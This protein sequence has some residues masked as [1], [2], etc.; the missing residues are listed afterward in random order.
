MYNKRGQL[1]ISVIVAIVIVGVILVL[2]LV[3]GVNPFVSADVN[4]SAFLIDC[5]E[6][7][8][9]DNLEI[10]GKQ[11]GYLEPSNSIT[12]LGGEI[13]YLCYT[14]ENFKPCI[15]QQ[16]LLL[17]HIEDEL[18]SV[19]QPAARACVR[20]LK[21]EYEQRGFTVNTEPG[22]VEVDIKS[23]SIDLSFNSPMSVTKEETQRFEKFG[24]SLESEM[25]D[26]ILTA[27]SVIDF[28]STLGDAETL[29]YIQYYPDLRIE[30]IEREGGTIYKLGNVVTGEEF[31]FASR[32]LVWPPG[33]GF[34]DI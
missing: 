30:K 24:I 19:V 14:N 13:Q 12:Y 7:V 17:K 5:I 9:K 6:P 11:G 1:T 8:L 33:Y 18:E 20:D 29:A 25:Y 26:L 28:E 4:P 2:F 32:S 23:G 10:L 16:P 34:G 3:P 15:V 21:T 31:V 22:D 27:T